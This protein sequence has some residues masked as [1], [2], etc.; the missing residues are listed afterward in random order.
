MVYDD[1]RKTPYVVPVLS[2]Q[3]KQTVE[4]DLKLLSSKG[5]YPYEY[6]DSPDKFKETALP[7]INGFYS[8]LTGK[9]I[10]EDEH[11]HAK[12][13]FEHFNCGSLQDYHDLYLRQDVLLLNDVLLEFRRVC[14]ETYN[15]DSMHYYTSPGI[16]LD[17]GLKF[18]GKTLQLLTENDMFLFIESG[19]KGGVSVISHRHAKANHPDLENIGYYNPNEPRR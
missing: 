15:V 13:V 2:T 14:L 16:T 3:Q 18:T 17:S 1:Y 6:M 4:E 8:S 5:I 12:H 7:N 11:L 19:L 10:T 9:T